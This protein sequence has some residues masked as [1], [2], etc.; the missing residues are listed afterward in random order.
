MRQFSDVC[1]PR[2]LLQGQPPGFEMAVVLRCAAVCVLQSKDAVLRLPVHS[3][4]F[5]TGIVYVFVDETLASG[6]PLIV[7]EC[8][9]R[10][11]SYGSQMVSR[12]ACASA[13]LF[14]HPSLHHIAHK[15]A[16]RMPGIFSALQP[17]LCLSYARN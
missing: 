4:N 14:G 3:T 2:E 6:S 16:L 11:T 9:R 7:R 10:K 15:N 17:T 1:L 13:L 12:N 5:A 8:L